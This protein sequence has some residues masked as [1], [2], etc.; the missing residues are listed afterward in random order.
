MGI[1]VVDR[2]LTQDHYSKDMSYSYCFQVGH[3][4]HEN[5]LSFHVEGPMDSI[6]LHKVNFLFLVHMQV[7]FH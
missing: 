5:I 6:R 4:K 1:H 3:R 7:N 2:A